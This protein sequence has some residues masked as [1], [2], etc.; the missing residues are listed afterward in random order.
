MAKILVNKLGVF[1]GQFARRSVVLAVSWQWSVD[2]R[3][4]VV[5]RTGMV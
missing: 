3:S 2:S 4:V 5:Y 1:G